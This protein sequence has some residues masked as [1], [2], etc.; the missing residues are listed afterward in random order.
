M[1]FAARQCN[2][3]ARQNIFFTQ[4]DRESTNFIYDATKIQGALVAVHLNKYKTN[5]HSHITTI[6]LRVMLTTS[7][8]F[9]SINL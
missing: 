5:N 7:P 1:E 2:P 6:H 9:F 4:Q 8:P 3:A